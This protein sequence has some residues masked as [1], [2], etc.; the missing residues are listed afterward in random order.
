MAKKFKINTP[1]FVRWLI[2]DHEDIEYWG[3]RVLTDLVNEGKV[4]FT[5]QELFD[6]RD[7][8]PGHLF[9]K[10][11]DSMDIYEGLDNEEIDINEIELI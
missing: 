8:L 10:Q 3:K 7:N 11:M 5:A 4:S 2:N 1:D 6:E 9:E